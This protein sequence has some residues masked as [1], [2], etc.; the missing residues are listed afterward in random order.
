MAAQIAGVLDLPTSE[1]V[2]PRQGFFDMGM[3]SLT[4]VEL[5]NRIQAD[6]GCS[7]PSTVAFDFPNL[8][9]L[10]GYLADNVLG[11]ITLE[12]GQSANKEQTQSAQDV[13]YAAEIPDIRAL[14]RLSEAEAEAMLLKEL[15]A[16]DL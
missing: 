15:E 7:L 5:R 8:D 11:S 3:D 10:V 4:S 2:L 13:L 14:D 1:P 12:P 16:L 6:L 9:T